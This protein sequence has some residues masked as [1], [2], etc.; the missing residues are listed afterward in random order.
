M[1]EVAGTT[2]GTRTPG[3]HMRQHLHTE[4]DG[5]GLL[6][7]VE[8]QPLTLLPAVAGLLQHGVGRAPLTNSGCNLRQ[9]RR[10]RRRM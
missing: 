3:P 8:Q 7:G 9:T 2:R 5:L 1:T 10:P 6:P 4:I